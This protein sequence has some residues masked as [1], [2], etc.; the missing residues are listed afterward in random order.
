MREIL[1]IA[2]LGL[3]TGTMLVMAF[4][5]PGPVFREIGF[6]SG[7]LMLTILT[8]SMP[9]GSGISALGLGLGVIVFL[10]IASGWGLTA[11]GAGTARGFV[12]WGVI[13]ILE[14]TLKLAPVALLTWVHAL[15]RWPS[16]NPSDF[17]MLGCFA[18]SGFALAENVSLAVNMP[19]IA[20]DMSRQYGPSLGSIHL[21][22]GAWGIAGY[23]GHSAATGFIAGGWGLGL[24]LR[25]HL[26]RRWWIV[27]A[28][29]AAWI[30]LE[31]ALGNYYASTG[32]PL[33]RMLGNGRIT[34]W[35]FLALAL[36]IVA[37]DHSR[38][39]AT[40]VRSP[41]LRRRVLM[42]RTAAFRTRPPVPRSR[43]DAL[44]MFMSQLRLVNVVAWKMS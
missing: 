6:L 11:A 33:G 16:P 14:E 19:A 44:R 13:P 10:A 17:L 34:P 38:H 31:H 2:A 9:A 3:F 8:R 1:R 35:L 37:L 32:S 22:P 27:P 36:A 30:V 21:V 24:A 26:G 23:A 43:V 39:H 5:A 4:H 42:T 20:A 12:Y 28:V 7:I 29:C 41:A 15:R 18:G 25:R 40:F